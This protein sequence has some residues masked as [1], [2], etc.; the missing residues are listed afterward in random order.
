MGRL[1]VC[2]IFTSVKLR[3]NRTADAPPTT[4]KNSN[5]N[6]P[7]RGFFNR[8]TRFCRF[9]RLFFGKDGCIFAFGVY[10][11]IYDTKRFKPGTPHENHP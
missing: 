11:I 4:I 7:F 3:R 9:F 6:T 5:Y 1:G 2:H 8:K 10:L